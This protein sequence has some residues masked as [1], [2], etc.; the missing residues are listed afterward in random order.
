MNLIYLFPAVLL[1]IA[2]VVLYGKRVMRMT[3]GMLHKGK[4]DDANPIWLGIGMVGAIAI[5]FMVKH[6][7]EQKLLFLIAAAIG[8]YAFAR[9]IEKP[10]SAWSTLA[11]VSVLIFFVSWD[12]TWRYVESARAWWS[13]DFPY[14]IETRESQKNLVTLDRF[15]TIPEC[16]GDNVWSREVTVPTGYRVAWSWTVRAQ[17]AFNSSEFT[18][19]G[20]YVDRNSDLFR[21]CAKD[22][23]H[24]GGKMP[25][26]WSV[27]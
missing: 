5:Y 22:N 12:P 13:S 2:G 21:Y 15:V 25:L 23:Q 19:H 20:A 4:E 1:I 27:L 7:A 10:P 6:G 16:S 18:E 9:W 11:L 26:T 17:S 8:I 3:N 14:K 24:V